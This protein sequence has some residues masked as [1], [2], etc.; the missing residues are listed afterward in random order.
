MDPTFRGMRAPVPTSRKFGAKLSV[1]M[2]GLVLGVLV[3]IAVAISLFSYFSTDPNQY[4]SQR[5]LGRLKTVTSLT[6][7]AQRQLKDPGLLKVNAE[8]NVILVGDYNTLGRIIPAMKADDT[9]LKSYQSA[10]KSHAA[11][12]DSKLSTARINGYYDTTY[13]S[14]LITELQTLKVSV[15]KL[16]ASTS[17]TDLKTAYKNLADHLDTSLKHLN[18]L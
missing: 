16:Y 5:M 10:E 14:L 8:A 1:K 17:N 2:I 9:Q 7:G 12:L 11:S 3:F 4:D 13:K 18:E 6:N 15:K